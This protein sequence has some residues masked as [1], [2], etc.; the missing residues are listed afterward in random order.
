MKE[1]GRREEVAYKIAG[2]A[3]DVSKQYQPIRAGGYPAKALSPLIATL[4]APRLD[5]N[6]KRKRN[7]MAIERTR[8]NCHGCGRSFTAELDMEING[9]VE[10]DCP[11]CGHPHYR[12]VQGGRVTGERYNPNIA[13]TYVATSYT[14]NNSETSYGDYQGT[15]S[16]LYSSWGNAD[17][18]TSGSW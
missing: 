17:S 15:S 4:T 16:Y 7:E 13:T 10:I 6:E 9:Q 5:K 12:I 1:V 18:T 2:R 8:L 14:T 3:T 11:N